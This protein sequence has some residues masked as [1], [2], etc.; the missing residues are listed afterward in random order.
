MTAETTAGT[1]AGTTV[2]V[3]A[4]PA[5]PLVHYGAALRRAAAGRP[6]DLHL[7]DPSAARPPRRLV[8]AEWCGAPRPGDFGLLARCGSAPGVGGTLDVGCGPGRL[9]AAL[10]SAGVPALGIDVC[11]EAI[12]QARRRGAPAR[13]VDVFGAVPDN[14]RGW[15]HVLLADGNIGIGGDP[16]RLL[17]RCRELLAPGGDILLELDPPGSGSWRGLAALRH[18]RRTSHPFPWAALAADDLPALADEAALAVRET[19]REA[20][21]WFA[22][23]G[24]A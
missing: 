7:V 21:R 5:A 11:P 16:R 22:R 19:W 14:A 4:G 20:R 2:G 12:S 8:L 24:P 3:T 9:T 15:R 6:T 10:A 17:T 23:I 18:G 13:L 1:T